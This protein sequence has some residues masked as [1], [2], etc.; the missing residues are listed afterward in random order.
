MTIKEIIKEINESE[1]GT[2]KL[3]LSNQEDL[4]ITKPKF[5]SGFYVATNE[6]SWQVDS[7][8]EDTLNE[9]IK[10]YAKELKRSYLGVW[11]D[12]RNKSYLL[13]ITNYYSDKTTARAMMQINN[14]EYIFDIA[15]KA[16]IKYIE[17]F[18]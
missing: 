12:K 10:L 9:Y 8:D 6:N 13:E 1:G 17:T 18:K 3:D 2:Y 16:S 7:L 15:N 14:Q 11:H 5:I 4:S